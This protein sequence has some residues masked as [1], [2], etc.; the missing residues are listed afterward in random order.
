[1]ALMQSLRGFMPQLR[2]Q[3]EPL[4][5]PIFKISAETVLQLNSQLKLLKMRS[6]LK[7]LK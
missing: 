2:S 3:A 5:S 1:M 7:L 6:W 4:I